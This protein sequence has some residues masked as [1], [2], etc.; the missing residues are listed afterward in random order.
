VSVNRNASLVVVGAGVILVVSLV[1]AGVTAAVGQSVPIE[2]WVSGAAIT[3]LIGGLLIPPPGAELEDLATLAVAIVHGSAAR[4]AEER[5]AKASG[6]SAITQVARQLREDQRAAIH[7]ARGSGPA[8]GAVIDAAVASVEAA[9]ASAQVSPEDRDAVMRAARQARPPAED[10]VMWGAAGLR[11]RN[12]F[13]WAKV[14]VLLAAFAATLL[15]AVTSAGGNAEI[16]F[17]FAGAAGGALIGLF[18]TPP[19]VRR[20][21]PREREALAAT[22]TASVQS[23]GTDAASPGTPAAQPDGGEEALAATTTAPVQ[24]TETDATSQRT[25]AAQPDGGEGSSRRVFTWIG[26]IAGLTLLFLLI[27]LLPSLLPK[28][29][30]TGGAGFLHYSSLV[31]LLASAGSLAGAATQAVQKRPGW[32]R[33][34]VIWLVS[35]TLTAVLG[36]FASFGVGV[37]QAHFTKPTADCV[38]FFTQLDQLVE[39]EPLAIAADAAANDSRSKPC[40]FNPNTAS[41]MNILEQLKAK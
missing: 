24:S 8:A 13:D 18:A 9:L 39:D 29:G 32:F 14:A 35:G 12:Y 7:D 19:S 10:V 16:L 5:I 31:L 40:K 6:T 26:L 36:G 38:A 28:W 34:A 22:T 41:G 27:A 25:P 15:L 33:R 37:A 30:N 20:E 1:A 3:G 11:A 21:T 23:T 17:V 2:L 4:A